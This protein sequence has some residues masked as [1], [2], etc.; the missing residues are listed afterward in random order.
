MCEI[1]FI[2]IYSICLGPI[3]NAY[4]LTSPYF[5]IF[6]PLLLFFSFT[7]IAAIG[8]VTYLPSPPSSLSSS[9]QFFITIS[10][11]KLAS[12]SVYFTGNVNVLIYKFLYDM[13]VYECVICFVLF[14]KL[15]Y[16]YAKVNKYVSCYF[17]T[18][19]NL[20]E[21]NLADIIH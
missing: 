2:V 3:P 4:S 5:Y 9:L 13:R 1:L 6:P 14:R 16:K 15:Y 19:R 7:N 11:G 8:D 12:V 10:I 18:T 17:A 21:H 20:R